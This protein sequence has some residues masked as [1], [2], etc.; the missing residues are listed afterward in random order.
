MFDQIGLQLKT[1]FIEEYKRYF[2]SRFN[3]NPTNNDIYQQ[4]LFQNHSQIAYSALPINTSQQSLPPTTKITFPHASVPYTNSRCIAAATVKKVTPIY[5]S[6]TSIS[7]SLL[8][9]ELDFGSGVR[10]K[11]IETERTSL[12]HSLPFPIG[13][14]V[15]IIDPEFQFDIIMLKKSSIIYLG[16]ICNQEVDTFYKDFKSMIMFKILKSK[17]QETSKSI[18]SLTPKLT[19][20]SEA[21]ALVDEALH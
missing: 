16:G 18:L 10:R 13:C 11:A 1:D 21:C 7:Y 17:D 19:T 9:L 14:K 2:K 20:L 4:W 12:P 3:R 5:C 8:E 6:L 15:I